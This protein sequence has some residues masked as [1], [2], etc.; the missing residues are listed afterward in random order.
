[1]QADQQEDPFDDSNS[2]FSNSNFL[3]LTKRDTNKKSQQLVCNSL[4]KI[5]EVAYQIVEELTIITPL[6]V[7]PSRLCEEVETFYYQRKLPSVMEH[8][9]RKRQE[10]EKI[11]F[12]MALTSLFR[13]SFGKI[14]N[15]YTI[16]LPNGG[17][18]YFL[19]EDL[20]HLPLLILASHSYD[21]SSAL[22]KEGV[23]YRNLPKKEY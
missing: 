3:P 5:D 18:V 21:F 10:R 14:S 22:E 9:L 17:I 15:K 8:E 4:E 6:E 11:D 2:L 20:E 13:K 7:H 12:I 19:M 1:M 23:K 16:V